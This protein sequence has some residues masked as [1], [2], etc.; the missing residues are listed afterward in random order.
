[1]AGSVVLN[2]KIDLTH[3]FNIAFDIYFGP[4]QAADGMAFVLHN[5]PN[6]VNAIGGAGSNLGAIGL[7]NGLA[8]EFDTWQNVNLGDPS[9][10]HTRFLDTDNGANLTPASNL[11]KIVD[12]GWHQVGVTWDAQAHTL[13]Y[14]VDGKLGGT[15]TADIATKFLGGQTTAYAEFTGATGGAHDVQQV[16]VAAV[17]ASLANISHAN[18]QD[19][20]E[21]S[22]SAVVNGAAN[23]DAV[24]HTFVLTPD[25]AG[26]AGSVMLNQRIDLSYDFQASFDLYL[27]KNAN[28]ADGMAFVLQNDAR[29]TKAIG[30]GGG[31]FGAVGIQNGV[32]IAFDTWQNASLGDMAGDHTNFFK[33]GGLW[34]PAAS[35]T[36]SRSVMAMS[37]MGSGTMFWSVGARRTTP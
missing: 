2:D 30:G 4:K 6:G 10:N 22:N 29:G 19:P 7:K 17:D 13:R 9:Y 1:M 3:D 35:A 18:V 32:G 23:Y 36:S 25:V 12:G 27:G 11:G 8:I 16:R 28:G 5:D 34:L 37:L 31:N 14:W 15:L 33:T 20:I 26:K 24:H 21:L